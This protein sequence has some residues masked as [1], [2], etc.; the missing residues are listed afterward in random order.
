MLPEVLISISPSRCRQSPICAT[1]SLISPSTAPSVAVAA[2]LSRFC[3]G[4]ET[5]GK[6]TGEWELVQWA[7]NYLLEYQAANV[8]TPVPPSVLVGNW[9]PPLSP[10]YKVNV[11]GASKNI[12]APLGP[13]EIEAKA[14]EV[15][16][17]FAKDVGIYDLILEADSL[18]MYRALAGIS[19]SPASVAAIVYGIEAA[20]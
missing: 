14:F 13:L 1:E 20:S 11:D 9:I 12:D 19:P 6:R 5:C 17:Q 15:G 7:K 18:V 2:L 3:R 16:L 10:Q 4:P 8:S